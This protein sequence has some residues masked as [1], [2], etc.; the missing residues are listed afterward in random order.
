MMAIEMPRMKEAIVLLLPLKSDEIDC[1]GLSEGFSLCRVRS[2]VEHW[3]IMEDD[4]N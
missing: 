3:R 1:D 4:G 2:V